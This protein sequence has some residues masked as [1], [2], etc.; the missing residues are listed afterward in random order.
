MERI[1]LMRFLLRTSGLLAL[2][3]TCLSAA[4]CTFKPHQALDGSVGT[5]MAS[6]LLRIARVLET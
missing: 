3:M 1:G 2:A 6:C 4:G 5:A